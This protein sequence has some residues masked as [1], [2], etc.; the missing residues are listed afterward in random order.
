MN[1]CSETR[2]SGNSVLG[3]FIHYLVLFAASIEVDIQSQLIEG[4]LV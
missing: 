2:R 4:G 1:F 3:L